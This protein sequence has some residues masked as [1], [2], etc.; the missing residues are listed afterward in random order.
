MSDV[1]EP[2]VAIETDLRAFEYMPLKVAALRDSDLAAKATGEEFRAAV[3]LWCA[4]WH[5]LP[6]ASLPNDDHLLAHLIGMGR[7]QKAWRK[8]KSMALRGF[9]LCSDGR[10]YHPVIAD[11]ANKS[12]K[13][14]RRDDNRTRNATEA[15]RRRYEQRNDDVTS[16]VT[17]E[18]EQRDVDRGG[19]VTFTKGTKGNRIEGNRI[20]ESPLP[21][22]A[23]D[24]HAAFDSWNEVAVLRDLPRAQSFTDAR[25]RSLKNRLAECGGI[26][27]WRLAMAKISASSFL[28]GQNDKSWRAD[29]DFVL[30][31]SSFTKLMEGKYDDRKQQSPRTKPDAIETAF[32]KVNGQLGLDG[33]ATLDLDAE[34]EPGTLALERRPTG[35]P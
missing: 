31:Q 2:L 10:L 33:P 34:R 29:I 24:L 26:E 28:C 9:I 5:Q 6:A 21:P 18:N 4:A 15:R 7:D 25:K 32:A 30:Q 11:I 1:P 12:F 22:M 14:K 17:I 23:D 8:V 3:L 27:G 20:E 35:K 13:T 19:N 16:N